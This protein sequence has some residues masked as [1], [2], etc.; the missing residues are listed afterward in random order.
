MEKKLETFVAP[1]PKFHFTE[2]MVFMRDMTFFQGFQLILL[3]FFICYLFSI[4]YCVCKFIN[5]LKVYKEIIFIID[6]HIA[7]VNDYLKNTTVVIKN[8]KKLLMLIDE[9]KRAPTTDMVENFS[10]TIFKKI[11]KWKTFSG[12][13]RK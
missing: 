8:F 5:Q 1:K 11:Y 13:L 12:K 4:N 6:T 9:T 7:D 3:G 10:K 2:V